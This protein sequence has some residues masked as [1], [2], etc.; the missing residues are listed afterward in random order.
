MRISA[1]E[2]YF[3]ALSQLDRSAYLDCF[4]AEAEL[5]DPYGG[6]SFIGRDEIAKWFVGMERTWDTFSMKPIE[7]YI[8]GD[9]IAVHWQASGRTGHGKNGKFAGINVF[10]VNDDG[11][12]TRLEGYWDIR[13]MMD[14]IS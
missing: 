4:S 12:I 8:S 7:H 2:R 13:A 11:L 14:Q 5:L 6:K 10:T 1:S 9:R 3:S